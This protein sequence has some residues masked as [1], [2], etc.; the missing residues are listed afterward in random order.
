MSLSSLS[1]DLY[2]LA[3]IGGYYASRLS[4]HATFDL[5]VRKLP[6]TRRFLIAAGLDQA[7]EFLEGYHFTDEDIA[8]VRQIPSL[9][10]LPRAFF[11]EY[12]PSFRFTGEVWAVAE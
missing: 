6:P 8:F 12:L 4:G 5:F 2:E 3:M 7:L 9:A 11:D 10:E 1:T